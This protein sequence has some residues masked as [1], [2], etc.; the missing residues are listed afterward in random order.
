MV[1]GGEVLVE[2]GRHDLAPLA[3]W[4]IEMR[5]ARLATGGRHVWE[6]VFRVS[7]VL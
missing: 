6:G 2:V 1:L 4:G 5:R 7:E 3:G